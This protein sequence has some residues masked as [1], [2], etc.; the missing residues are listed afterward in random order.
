MTISNELVSPNV[1]SVLIL[2][3]R[4]EQSISRAIIPEPTHHREQP[5]PTPCT[6]SAT[7]GS[8]SPISLPCKFP[9]FPGRA[10]AYLG[11]WC[12][13]IGHL[14]RSPQQTALVTTFLRKTRFATKGKASNFEIWSMALPMDLL[15]LRSTKHTPAGANPKKIY[16]KLNKAM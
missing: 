6:P 8:S 13:L 12:E 1:L 15:A 3:L 11:F 9:F 2:D 10:V 7:T 4:V 5:T 14:S 16:W